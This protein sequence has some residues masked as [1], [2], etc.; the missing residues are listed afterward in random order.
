M[1]GPSIEPVVGGDRSELLR[2]GRNGPGWWKEGKKSLKLVAL[3]HVTSHVI[4]WRDSV[5]AVWECY[6]PWWLDLKS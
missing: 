6:R 1:L 4:R 3:V 5:S 2:G